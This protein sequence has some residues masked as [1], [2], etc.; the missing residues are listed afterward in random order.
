MEEKIILGAKPKNRKKK[1]GLRVLGG[2]RQPT[3]YKRVDESKRNY[4]I[5]LHNNHPGHGSTTIDIVRGMDAA[6]ESCER[7]NG[8]LTQEQRDEGWSHFTEPTT[9]KPW[10][11]PKRIDNNRSVKSAGK[12]R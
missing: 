10:S 6:R 3:L 9:K 2:H 8:Q 7:H 11:K 5:I 1:K 12:K 4:E